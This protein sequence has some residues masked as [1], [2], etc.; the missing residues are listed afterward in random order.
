MP[1]L[2]R[3]TFHAPDTLVLDEGYTACQYSL[4]FEELAA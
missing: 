4:E 2:G 3:N 1:E